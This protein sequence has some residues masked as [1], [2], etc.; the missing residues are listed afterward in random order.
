MWPTAGV[1]Y[2]ALVFA[3]G[4]GVGVVRTLLLE[5]LVGHETAVFMELPLMVL[6][7]AVA[8]RAACR[9]L[10]PAATRTQAVV[11]GFIG[12]MLLIGSEAA[13]GYFLLGQSLQAQALA[14]LQPAGLAALIAFAIYTAGPAVF[15]RR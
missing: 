9:F 15:V 4:F 12:L 2:W 14:Y 3:V 8:A 10:A 13:V 5:P 6:V 11:I 7:C 1:L